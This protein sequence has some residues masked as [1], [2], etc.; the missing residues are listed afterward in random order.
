M[1]VKNKENKIRSVVDVLC[2][3]II[4]NRR[5]NFFPRSVT[6]ER[7]LAGVVNQK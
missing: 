1:V 4:L 6:L 2:L 7:L 3:D 5:T